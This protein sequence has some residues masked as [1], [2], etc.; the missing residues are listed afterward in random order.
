MLCHGLKNL[1]IK[2]KRNDI[3]VLGRMRVSFQNNY[4]YK[5]SIFTPQV[6]LL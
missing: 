5:L 3:V 2:S 6:T 4:V 1:I